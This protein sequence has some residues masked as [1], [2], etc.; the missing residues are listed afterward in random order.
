MMSPVAR[1]LVNKKGGILRQRILLDNAK[2]HDRAPVQLC[3]RKP[4]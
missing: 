1:L 2:R 4:D 3:D